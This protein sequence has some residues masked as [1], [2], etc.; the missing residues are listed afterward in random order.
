M[1][2][3]TD[4]DVLEKAFA[5]DRVLVTANVND[6]LKLARAR[7]LH[8]GIVLIAHGG[9][10]RDEQLEV[11]QRAHEA[12]QAQRDMVN[13]VLYIALNGEMTFR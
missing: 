4:H 9:L 10:L 11:L 13:R 12:L 7:E 6:F 1:L 5:E 3:A 2:E 8:S